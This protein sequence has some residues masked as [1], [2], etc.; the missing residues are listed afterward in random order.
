MG[1][2]GFDRND[3]CGCF[4]D[5]K[6]CICVWFIP[7]YVHGKTA[8]A[9]GKSCLLHTVCVLIP[10]LDIY[11]LTCIRSEALGENIL[12]S[13]IVSFFL[14]PLSV[15]QVARVK[16]ADLMAGDQEDPMERV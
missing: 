9:M 2:I 5:I 7:C 14:W 10:I 1:L 13:L 3:L 12:I 6:V 8:E 15:C 16:N 11:D 4:T